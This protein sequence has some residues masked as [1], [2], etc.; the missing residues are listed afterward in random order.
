MA[1]KI[2]PK[3]LNHSKMSYR[4]LG[5]YGKIFTP[6]LA[7]LVRYSSYLALRATVCCPR[8]MLRSRRLVGMQKLYDIFDSFFCAVVHCTV[9]HYTALHIAVFSMFLCGN[10][11]FPDE[12]T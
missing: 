9:I 3:N 5:G 8:L 11:S 10:V 2:F 7:I 6:V 12:K 4:Y 1:P